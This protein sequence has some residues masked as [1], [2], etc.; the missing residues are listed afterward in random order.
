MDAACW[1]RRVRLLAANTKK[2]RINW[3]RH[4]YQWHWVSSGICLIGM[5]VFAVTGLTLNHAGQIESRPV[6]V[7]RDATLPAELVKQLA[8]Y[9]A[10]S[11]DDVP[12][13]INR[14]ISRQLG[15]NVTGRSAEWS[16]RDVYVSLP[17]PGGDAWLSIDRTDGAVQYEVTDRGWI[18]YLNDLHKGRH[19][20]TAWSWFIDI[21]SIGCVVFCVTGLFLLHMHSAKRPTTWPVVGAGLVI[22]ILLL[23]FLVHQ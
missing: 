3:L 9:P 6:T 2:R 21:F 19:T 23:V 10:V 1:R 4:L 14:W 20:G 11:K 5:L 17:R 22:P 13:D 15:V 16:A 7:S 12:L 18:A 8:T